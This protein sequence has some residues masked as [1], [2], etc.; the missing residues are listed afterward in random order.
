MMVAGFTYIFNIIQ[1]L[2]YNLA[3]TY[4]ASAILGLGAAVLWTSQ[5]TFLS[6]NSDA[7][8]VTRNF[9]VFWAMNTSSVFVGNLFAYYLFRDQEL[10]AKSD[11]MI[12]GMLLTIVS[13][14]GVGLMLFL[15]KTPWLEKSEDGMKEN[16]RSTIKLLFSKKMLMFSITFFYT[17]LH[18]VL[19][20]GVYA[21]SIG[22]TEG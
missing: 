20:G 3:S 17:G 9:G 21:T 5:G 10:I 16:F 7:R 6:I 8:T 11:R 15:R 22:L 1:L 2:Y 19:W 12:L 13:A 14:S 4:A 18:Q